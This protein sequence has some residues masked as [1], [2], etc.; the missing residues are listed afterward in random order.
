MVSTGLDKPSQF[1]RS[2][3]IRLVLIKAREGITWREEEASFCFPLHACAIVL[4]IS[5]F[6]PTKTGPCFV[7]NLS[8]RL[9]QLKF[10]IISRP[11]NTS[12][13]I[14]V[15]KKRH[16]MAGILVGQTNL[17]IDSL[18]NK[19]IYVVNSNKIKQ[20]RPLSP[21]THQTGFKSRKSGLI[22][23]FM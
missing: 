18:K 2:L 13:P 5:P 3:R 19:G 12:Q 16:P 21:E 14:A 20:R 23:T 4:E 9:N 17:R 11:Y 1:Y 15:I 10:K 6:A 22:K 7:G 8:W